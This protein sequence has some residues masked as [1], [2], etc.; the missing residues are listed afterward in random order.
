M[1]GTTSDK[2]ALL[3]Q[4]KEAFRAA[5]TGKGQ[6]ISDDE[7]YSAWPAK[8]SA[9]ETGIQLPTLTNP[10]AAAD[11]R[12]GKQLIDQEGKVVDGT[13][14]EVE[15]ATPSIS[16]SSAGLITATAGDK[17]ATKQIT[18]A[19][20]GYL[21]PYYIRKGAVIFGVAGSLEIVTSEG[22]WYSP[23]ELNQYV[24]VASNTLTIK[25]RSVY[26]ATLLNFS[27]LLSIS[28]Q[29]N[30]FSKTI[31]LY[32]Y[33]GS[34]TSI[35]ACHVIYSESP[36]TNAYYENECI[37]DNQPSLE[38][39]TDENGMT[40]LKVTSDI[41]NTVGSNSSSGKTYWIGSIRG[42]ATVLWP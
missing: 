23:T 26:G 18:S 8:V 24:T 30:T 13:L 21:S 32:G 38:V 4:I 29:Y 31:F 7:P 37:C 35:P 41:F 12:Q 10:G 22:T 33:G 34:K 36:V 25:L 11:L 15:Q 17:S 40:T 42:D 16:V 1:A 20:C 3:R 9:I 19:D 5:I 14:V 27:F 6:T 28:N 2:L 39:T